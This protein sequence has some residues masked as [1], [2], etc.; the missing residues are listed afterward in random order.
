MD[1]YIAEK[2]I[3]ALE[4]L[5][6]I[7][8]QWKA[9]RHKALDGEITFRYNKKEY[10]FFAEVKSE[11]R[12]NQ[13]P[14]I[15]AQK[16][17]YH[18]LIVI[19]EYIYPNLK[20]ELRKEGI[21]YLETNGNTYIKD[22]DIYFW[23][24]GKKTNPPEEKP[25]RAFSKTGLR[26][27]FHFL[28][29]ESLVNMTY[30]EIAKKTGVS[31]GNINVIM[32]ALRKQ[33]FLIEKDRKTFMLVNKKSL[34]DTWMMA[35]RD[36]LKPSLKIATFRFLKDD[37]YMQWKK[38]PLKTGETYWGGEPAAD[39]LTGYLKPGEFTLYTLEKRS[40]LIKRYRLVPDET[41]N[42]NVYQKFWEGNEENTIA[43]PLL[44]Y[45]D[46]MNTGDRRCIETAQKIYN[47]YLQ[48]TF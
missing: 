7:T 32:T 19:A 30:R 39:L 31:F 14:K 38:L 47:E 21:A 24:D 4:D 6:D 23:L 25:G 44:I 42:I 3:T 15:L 45:A 18:P 40:D 36:K 35:Y 17:T 13:L 22:K 8:M 37:E 33:G 28:A 27:I 20:K 48:D 43:P 9:S 11:L 5:I 2:A 41:G 16:A 29:D 1:K 46:L 12:N 10:H 34:L 26:L